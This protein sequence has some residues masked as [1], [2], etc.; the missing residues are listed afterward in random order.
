MSAL[1]SVRAG[2][3]PTAGMRVHTPSET[4]APALS[5]QAAFFRAAMGTSAEPAKTAE[6]APAPKVQTSKPEVKLA[7]GEMP[8]RLL[9]PGSLLDIRV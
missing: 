4:K 8:S 5:G 6:A 9:R 7:E 3:T 1:S 2:L